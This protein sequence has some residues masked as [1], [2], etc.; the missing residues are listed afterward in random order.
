MMKIICVNGPPG[1]GKDTVGT[2][3]NEIY[4]GVQ[5]VKFA[6]P[7]D[8]IVMNMLGM[9][10]ETFQ[11]YRNEKKEEKLIQW[12]C[13]VTM[14]ELLI[15]ISE[16]LIK[17]CFSKIWFAEQ[18][19]QRVIKLEGYN[20]PIVITD[21]GFQYEF[22]HFKE[23]LKDFAD[24]R[25]IQLTRKGCTFDNDSREPVSDGENT[26]YINNDGTLDELKSLLT[27]ELFND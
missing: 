15:R 26:I 4:G 1:S 16:G 18:C 7:M 11:I 6:G 25:L 23:C 12:G 27:L 20:Q 24:I 5:I 14:R 3:L 9:D 2:L 10:K 21:S 13:H 22:D 8:D 19:A 17:P